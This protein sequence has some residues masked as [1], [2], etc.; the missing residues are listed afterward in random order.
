MNT[1]IRHP[2]LNEADLLEFALRLATY[3]GDSSTQNAQLLPGQLPAQ[4]PIEMPI[5]EGSRVLGSLVRNPE[6]IDIYLDLTLSPEQVFMFYNQRMKAAGWQTTDIFQPD[7]GGLMEAGA[8]SRGET[9]T[10]YQG[11]RVPEATI[12]AL[13]DDNRNRFGPSL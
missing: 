3:P 4:L 12:N 11:L 2:S 13:E 8:R 1:N 9:E 6:K 7:R 5:P 10:F